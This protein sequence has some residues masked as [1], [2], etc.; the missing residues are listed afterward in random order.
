MLRLIDANLNRFSEGLRLLEDVA[1]FLLNDAA[2]SECVV[3]Y[4]TSSGG[5]D[6]IPLCPGDRLTRHKKM[7]AR[8]T[9]MPLFCRAA[10]P[11]G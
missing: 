2:L 7:R 11:D 10:Y 3:W 8:E 5:G 9:D 4:D 1:R 6:F